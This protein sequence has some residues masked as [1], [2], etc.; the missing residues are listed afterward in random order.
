MTATTGFLSF[1]NLSSAV[2]DIF[3]AR[4]SWRSIW[5]LR[6]VHSFRAI[7]RKPRVSCTLQSMNEKVRL[8]EVGN[9]L[10]DQL[11]NIYLRIQVQSPA[12][13]VVVT[14]SLAGRI[15]CRLYYIYPSLLS[16]AAQIG[17]ISIRR[18]AFVTSSLSQIANSYAM[19]YQ[20]PSSHFDRA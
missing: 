1:F 2:L 6:S 19:C 17:R 13:T 10:L 20:L 15:N 18:V 3:R 16:K 7:R 8:R 11:P 4:S 12:S 5:I 14:W 9:F